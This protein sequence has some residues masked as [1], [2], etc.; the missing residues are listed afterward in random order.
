LRVRCTKFFFFWHVHTRGGRRIRTSDLY[1]MRR[2]PQ[3]IELPLGD[4]RCTKLR[5][6]LVHKIDFWNGITLFGKSLFLGIVILIE[7]IISLWKG[8]DYIFHKKTTHYFLF[9]FIKK[10]KKN[11]YSGWPATLDRLQGWLWP[12]PMRLRWS[13][14]H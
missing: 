2:D 11:L 1:F 12:P 6:Y 3:P 8:I 9:S 5:L 4:V 10:K 14:T 13:A 7:I